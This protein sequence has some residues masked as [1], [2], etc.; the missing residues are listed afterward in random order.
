MDAGLR[1]ISG[2]ALRG[3]IGGGAAIAIPSKK[4]SVAISANNS[5]SFSGQL[6]VSEND[7]NT[8]AA[9][10]QATTAYTDVLEAYSI[11]AANVTAIYD[12]IDNGDNSRAGE[13]AGALQD[14]SDAEDDVDGFQYGTTGGTAGNDIFVGGAL[15]TGA[16]NLT[17]DSTVE[18]AAV[19]I[20]EVGL[21]I[22]REFTIMERQVAIGVTPKLQRIDA[23]NYIVSVE[24]ETETDDV[25]ELGVEETGF[26][27]DI[28]ASTK[29]GA[30]QQGTIGVVIKNILSKDIETT[31]GNAATTDD[32]V[33]SIAPQ[34]RVGVAY[35]ALGWVHLAADLDLTENEPVAFENPT[36]FAS[37]GAEADVFGFLQVR[38]GYRTNLAASGQNVV[39]GGIGLS[40]FGLVHIDIGAY[41]NASDPEK[42]AGAVF[43]FG[44]DW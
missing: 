25:D 33:I 43:E 6:N 41:A 26:N 32:L 4:F 20:S 9:Y 10:T 7:L 29:F 30:E 34:V 15:A 13:L 24:D 11:E 2:K 21:S 23:Y 8:L 44:L 3:G 19:A 37:L 36:Q 28:G 39:S 40:P 42:E 12:N 1:S 22:S 38:A 14:L 31:D 27:L 35:E 16:D 17:L 18:I 5:T